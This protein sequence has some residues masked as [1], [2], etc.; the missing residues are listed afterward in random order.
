MVTKSLFK[1]TILKD[2]VLIVLIPFSDNSELKNITLSLAF[3]FAATLD[4]KKRVN[5][6]TVY[7]YL[8]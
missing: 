8:I 4:A 2:R 6:V 1:I 3:I 7:C 5:H